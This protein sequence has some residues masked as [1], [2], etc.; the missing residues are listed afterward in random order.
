[1]PIPVVISAYSDRTFTFITKK[2]P[3]SYFIKKAVKI[4]SGSKTPGLASAGTITMAQ[5][6]ELAKEKMVDM[7]ANTIE[8][9]CQMLVGSARSMGIQVVE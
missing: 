5:I 2:P 9:A 7:N 3:N 4:E 8:A 1:M 6:R